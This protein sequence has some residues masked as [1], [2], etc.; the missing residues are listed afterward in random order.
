MRIPIITVLIYV[1]V[2]FVCDFFIWKQVAHASDK[3][4]HSH[5][6]GKR[7]HSKR[8][9]HSK[10]GV[11]AK[12]PRTVFWIST[13]L[14]WILITV[15]LAWPYRTASNIVPKM[16]M[17]YVWASVYCS[18][19]IYLFWCLPGAITRRGRRWHTGRYM[20]IPLGVAVFG[21]MWW[22]ALVNRNN[23][24]VNR[25]E[26]TSAKVPASFNG[27]RIAQISDL[28]LGTWGNDTTFVSSLVDSVNALRP[29]LIV[30][31]GDLVNR[32]ASEVVPFMTVLSRLKAPHGVMAVL[33]NHDY[34]MYFDWESK[35]AEQANMERFVDME[36]RMGWTL[37]RN[38]YMYVR[39]DGEAIAVV[40]VENWGEPPY[41]SFG[42]IDKAL[43]TPLDSTVAPLGN[44]W[45]L[46]LSH[47]PE[48]WDRKLNK[49]PYADLTLSGHTHA[50]QMSVTLNGKEYSPAALKYNQWSGLYLNE[51]D[52][53]SGELYVNVGAGTVGM[54]FRIGATPEI[55]LFTLHSQHN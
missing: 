53:S 19:G 21:L 33:G 47:N 8:S 49:H 10:R 2:G 18:K 36:K 44:Q 26:I 12:W 52:A 24:D 30:F 42:D 14:C 39:H 13:V 41:P 3:G 50:M 43:H 48:Y 46:L 6:K 15:A 51:H 11:S 1:V 22:G 4:I 32:E 5:S 20:G 9:R 28:H 16:W 29:D 35:T 38:Q 23:I 34:G 25:V 27:F 31:T 37:L 45:R 7:R 55:S 40:G 54:P 17:L